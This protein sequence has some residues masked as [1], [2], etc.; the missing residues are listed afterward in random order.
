MSDSEYLQLSLTGKCNLKCKGCNRKH[1]VTDL[2]DKNLQ[3][4]FDNFKNV[5]FIKLQGMGEPFLTKDFDEKIQKIKDYYKDVHILVITN[6]TVDY[7]KTESI[8]ALKLIDQ[9]YV[10]MN[11]DSETIFNI[12]VRNIK[13][14]RKYTDTVVNCVFF[15]DNIDFFNSLPKKLDNAGLNHIPVRVQHY[16]DWNNDSKIEP[17]DYDKVNW[18]IFKNPQFQYIGRDDFNYKDCLWNDKRTFI[19]ENGDIMLCCLKPYRRISKLKI[20]YDYEISRGKLQHMIHNNVPPTV[21]CKTCSFKL[22][23]KIN[24]EI[25]RRING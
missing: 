24:N 2:S 22:L 8:R 21:E 20:H 25:L 4:V 3:Y 11:N 12:K 15:V 18:E 19:D 9:V 16:Q 10:S 14:M 1:N 17:I 13:L 5:K 6:G 23:N 7:T